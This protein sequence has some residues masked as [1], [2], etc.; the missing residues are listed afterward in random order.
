[1]TDRGYLNLL[2]HLTRP[3]TNLPLQT[4][5]GSIAHYL[6]H[7]QPSPTPLAATIVSSPF[8]RNALYERLDGLSAA[9]RHAIHVKVKA[10]KEE[11]RGVFTRSLYSRLD[12]WVREVLNGLQGGIPLLRL[13]CYT[14]MVQG[15]EDWDDEL[16][17]KEG[18]IRR[19]VEEELV[20]VLA[21]VMDEFTVASSTGWEKEF[22][23]EAQTQT[24]E[25]MLQ[26]TF[27]I[28]AKAIPL[29]AHERLRV[30]PLAS[31]IRLLLSTLE[32]AFEGGTFLRALTSQDSSLLPNGLV[33]SKITTLSQSLLLLNMSSLSGMCSQ[34]LS[35]LA[36]TRP[37]EAWLV[38]QEI[39][40]TF[41]QIS[42]AI[43][44]DWLKVPFSRITDENELE[45][46]A[47]EVASAT[48]LVLKTLLFTTIRTTQSLL[49]VVIY[50]PQPPPLRRSPSMRSV[51]PSG[52]RSTP[53]TFALTTL[54]IFSNLAFTLPQ[55]GGLSSTAESGFI[56][57]KKVFYTALDVLAADE[58]ES[59]RFMHELRES[60]EH[61]YTR[62]QAWPKTFWNAKKAYALACA[63]QLAKVLNEDSIKNDVYPL[64]ASHLNDSS[65][66]ET[67]ESAH[68]VML[69][70]FGAHSQKAEKLLSSQSLNIKGNDGRL[71]SFAEQAVP[72]YTQ[73]LIDN[74]H[75]EKLTFV[76]LRL[77][78]RAL[79]RS[80]STMIPDGDTFAWFCV[81][82]LIRALHTVPTDPEHQSSL[83]LALIAS[84]SAVNLPVLP[85]V[86]DAILQEIKNREGAKDAKQE[87]VGA[88]FE[89]IS[90]RVGD[91]GKEF[92]M[93]WWDEN[94]L[95]LGRAVGGDGSVGD[96][97]IASGKES[98]GKGK[99]RETVSR[100]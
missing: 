8:F 49:S 24:A 73:C 16:K 13:A 65:H 88:L 70:I 87:A 61:N 51:S 35:I 72:F 11:P 71:Q 31:L 90:E 1:M 81:D 37:S 82:S 38:M 21:E 23:Q 9:F 77:A 30:L 22:T 84:T 26:L 60:M 4:I 6:A 78:Y 63:E 55:F 57:L 75:P 93:K 27:L 67:Y 40:D 79:V 17:T 54:Q 92:A 52:S 42:S 83:L 59:A 96:D 53:Y 89:E 32:E 25:G 20:V 97:A 3:T 91:E 94:K 5:Q 48:W 64:V 18:R 69:A 47:R 99:E 15:L 100:L 41:I 43:E 95:R 14:G 2:S 33:S 74:S 76:Q 28:A 62:T 29:T 98:S 39:T 50:T 45:P 7:V 86:L 36:D 19:K 58:L 85:M 44:G 68:S 66:R 80:A 12:V 10:L 46:Q 34:L 56:E